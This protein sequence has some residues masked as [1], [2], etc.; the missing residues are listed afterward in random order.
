MQRPYPHIVIQDGIAFI[1]GTRVPARRVFEWH[2]RGT[3]MQVL[4]LRYPTIPRAY[5][6]NAVSFMYDHPEQLESEIAL[7]AVQGDHVQVRL[8]LVR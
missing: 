8:P 5:L 4:F 6:L 7:E 3:A 2:R 1:E